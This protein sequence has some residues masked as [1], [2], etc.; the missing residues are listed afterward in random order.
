MPNVSTAQAPEPVVLSSAQHDLILYSVVVAGLALFAQ[1]LYNCVSYREV[2][3]R[4]R[5]A[6][7]ASLCIAAVAA[8]SYLGIY[9]NLQSGYEYGDGVYR[10]TPDALH[11]ISPRYMDWSVTVPLLMAEL[12]AVCTLVGRRLSVLRSTTMAAA[13]VM[14]ATGYL[15]AKVFE[16]GSSAFW[17][18]LWW[19]ISM[20]F[21]GYLYAALIPAVL[22]SASELPGDAGRTLIWA[23]AVLLGS[24]LVYPVVYLIPVFF[25]GGWWTATMHVAFSAADIV[26]KVAFGMLIHKVAKLRTAADVQHGEDTHPEPVWVNHVHLSDGVLPEQRG[27]VSTAG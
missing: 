10:P 6:I 27:L 14:I 22:R 8:V 3:V 7:F 21:F 13:F 5:P 23:T 4:Y 18:W 2:S 11:T 12:L 15:G 9:A 19:G 16:Q 24:F 1:F 25:A 26:A 17:L 20:V